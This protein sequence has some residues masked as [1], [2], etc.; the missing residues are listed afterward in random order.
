MY[1]QNGALR[2][3]CGACFLSRSFCAILNKKRSCEVHVVEQY[4]DKMLYNFEITNDGNETEQE[5]PNFVGFIFYSCVALESLEF[6]LISV[7]I[8][9]LLPWSCPYTLCTGFRIECDPFPHAKYDYCIVGF[10]LLLHICIMHY[11]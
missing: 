3:T 4:V 7:C 2:K 11:V 10:C 6:W 1:S 9:L 8:L 5:D